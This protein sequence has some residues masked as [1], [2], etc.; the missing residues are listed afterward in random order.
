MIYFRYAN[1]ILCIRTHL[2]C[3]L[4]AGFF[5]ISPVLSFPSC[6]ITADELQKN[7]S[8]V[9]DAFCMPT[10]EVSNWVMGAI[11]KLCALVPHLLGRA[12]VVFFKYTA[13]VVGVA[14]ANHLRNLHNGKIRI[15]Q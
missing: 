6:K 8:K 4:F 13:E 7:T 9:S 11:L 10:S 12:S 2:S 3:M 1:Y 14:I 5:L 15:L